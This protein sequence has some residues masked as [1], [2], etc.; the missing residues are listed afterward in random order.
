[1]GLNDEEWRAL[2][3]GVYWEVYNREVAR[4][5]NSAVVRVSKELQDQTDQKFCPPKDL[6]RCASDSCKGKDGKCAED[7]KYFP[8][9]DCTDDNSCAKA[10]NTPYCDNCGGDK[11][12][13]KCQGVSVTEQLAGFRAKEFQING[14][15]WK[16]C[17]CL[18]TDKGF[19]GLRSF[20]SKDQFDQT[21]KLFG[22]LPDL[23]D[24]PDTNH[25][26]CELRKRVDGI[27]NVETK[28]FQS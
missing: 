20:D 12:G 3:V 17:T 22:S 10:E 8:K 7:A 19:R 4:Q 2:T 14:Q 18:R 5:S 15:L 21:Q 6:L 27:V 25:P 16:D 9:C 11:G 1:M 13:L 26:H 24:D 23:P 28:L